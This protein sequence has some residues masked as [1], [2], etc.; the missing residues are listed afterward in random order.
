MNEFEAFLEDIEVTEVS[1]CFFCGRRMT[2]LTAHFIGPF[3]GT[4]GLVCC[5][6]HDLEPVRNMTWHMVTLAKWYP[7]GD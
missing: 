3:K 6:E 2:T 5:P 1:R 7:V 4:G